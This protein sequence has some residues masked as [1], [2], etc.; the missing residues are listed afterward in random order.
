M[1]QGDAT[2]KETQF[3]GLPKACRIFR[4]AVQSFSSGSFQAV[5]FDAISYNYS[6]SSV[7]GLGTAS[8]G[9]QVS[10]PGVYGLLARGAMLQ[11]LANEY[12]LVINVNGAQLIIA[13]HAN[14]GVNPRWTASDKLELKAN[15]IVTVSVFPGSNNVSGI[16]GEMFLYVEKKGGQY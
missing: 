10:E 1:K 6:P 7:V 3:S 9:I 16:G 8:A 5:Q 13:T 2:S 11:S 15:D 12:Y 4:N 14:T